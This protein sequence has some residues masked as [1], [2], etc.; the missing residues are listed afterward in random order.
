MRKQSGDQG[1][2]ERF[3]ADIKAMLA[4][5]N[6][7]SL[8]C[9]IRECNPAGQALE[10]DSDYAQADE[11]R[12]EFAFIEFSLP[13]SGDYSLAVMVDEATKRRIDLSYLS[14]QPEITD[15]LRGKGSKEPESPVRDAQEEPAKP[16]FSSPRLQQI[17]REFVTE[18][19]QAAG[20]ALQPFAAQLEENLFDAADR[21]V[22]NQL[23]TELMAYYR[24][25]ADDARIIEA[26]LVAQLTKRLEDLES[27]SPP[28][29]P[30]HRPAGDADIESMTLIAPEEM[31][32]WVQ[33]TNLSAA[34]E[35]RNLEQLSHLTARVNALFH[36]ELENEGNPLSPS[37]V[38]DVL[39]QAL[40]DRSLPLAV[41]QVYWRSFGE[42]FLKGLSAL[43]SDLNEWLKARGVIPDIVRSYA[44]RKTPASAAPGAAG[45]A[46]G[47][48]Q[49]EEDLTVPSREIGQGTGWGG[50]SQT[51]EPVPAPL[52][53][54][55]LQDLFRG[56]RRDQGSAA[57]PG[58][59]EYVSLLEMLSQ[60]LGNVEE[61]LAPQDLRSMELA[62]T[63]FKGLIADH[64]LAPEL[65]DWV[66]GLEDLITATILND[67]SFIVRRSHPA[68]RFISELAEIGAAGPPL[69]QE[70]MTLLPAIEAAL[71]RG[72]DEPLTAFAEAVGRIE[73]LLE[74]KR[75]RDLRNLESTVELCQAEELLAQAKHRIGEMLVSRIG[76]VPLPRFLLDLIGI[77]WRHLLTLIL[78]QRGFAS[79]EWGEAL[80][81][82]DQLVKGFST[83][84]R[85]G[86]S[87]VTV[88]KHA[89]RLMTENRCSHVVDSQLFRKA[90]KAA[91]MLENGRDPELP[92]ADLE[93]IP[94]DSTE[95]GRELRD[96]AAE[97]TEEDESI[98][99]WLDRATKFPVGSWFL[100]T[101]KPQQEIHLRLSWIGHG[102]SRFVFV[103]SVGIKTLDLR[104]REF[105]QGLKDQQ[106][107][108]VQG[109]DIT[110]VDHSISQVLEK[111]YSKVAYQASHDDVTGLVNRN[112]FERRLHLALESANSGHAHHVLGFITVHQLETIRK[113]CGSD[114]ANAALREISNLFNRSLRKNSTLSRTGL[115][116]FCVLHEYCSRTEAFRLAR[117][118]ITLVE[119]YRYTHD[120]VPY[121]LAANI[122][123]VAIGADSEHANK[124]FNAAEVACATAQ[125]A[126][127][128]TIHV[129]CEGDETKFGLDQ[130]ETWTVRITQALDQDRLALRAQRIA[131][132]QS[133][134]EDHHYEILLSVLDEQGKPTAPGEFIEA[135]E[136]L[137]LMFDVDR[138]VIRQAFDWMA[139]NPEAMARLGMLSINLSG[140]SLGGGRLLEYIREQ[141]DA[142]QVP[143]F[144]ICFEITETA[145]I[146]NID[147]AIALVTELRA[148]GCKFSLD[149]FGSGLSSYGYLK[150]LPTDYLKID[151][152]LV[153][154]ICQAPSDLAMVRSINEIAHFMEKEVVAEYAE[155]Q[156]IVDKLRE[157]GVDYA[158]GW[159]VARPI[160]LADLAAQLSGWPHGHGRGESPAN[161]GPG[162]P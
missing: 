127:R 88:L 148:A 34:A 107:V 76:P 158:Q 97:R 135:A 15:A 25:R 152:S 6:G 126:G 44:V 32:S 96:W 40:R 103:N 39:A 19:L 101:P 98:G 77:G 27:P 160:P 73:P 56:F 139:S 121:P 49:G 84:A 29:A 62:E 81:L 120:K 156:E 54:Q 67:E 48:G 153:R 108:P 43:Y 23:Q 134:G 99:S 68:R 83:R 37:S 91:Y 124:V 21:A 71:A 18:A 117:K 69:D 142:Y 104:H 141:L 133:D 5:P 161:V 36:V 55:A 128:N 59:Q 33:M 22:S 138:W 87:R 65:R 116:Q 114:A 79:E 64:G 57:R 140:Q 70:L 24:R 2:R 115:D 100:H 109:H 92:A 30:A 12:G 144:Q 149:D 52:S 31:E 95:L 136:R 17:R 61:R 72:G 146:A 60:Q 28:S 147:E 122:G 157:L 82:T 93:Q 137:G 155:T 66:L 111:L 1:T 50:R 75:T 150:S 9:T 110:I 78:L 45:S 4:L 89:E 151:G 102:N 130:D 90:K 118:Y 154:D 20:K 129:F 16:G 125:R 3:R 86:V 145:A 13:G 143:E 38:C 42:T 7:E 11:L 105:A 26:A 119:G 123:L 58:E 14:P 80:A 162:A 132:L 47:A 74:R 41:K 159:G 63:V 46:S 131:A 35:R 85:Q 113:S 94:L 8:S 112:E 53:R 10:L 51:G 106:L